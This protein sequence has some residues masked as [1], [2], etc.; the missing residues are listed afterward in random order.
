MTYLDH[1]NENFPIRKTKEEKQRFRDYVIENLKE[2]GIE[3][4]V[5]RTKDGKN[6][7]VIV[8]D[9]TTATAVFTAHYD[10]PARSLFPNIMIP[11]NKLLFYSYQFV[12]II[13][14]LIISF[15]LAHIVGNVLLNDESAYYFTFLISYY[16]I[17][18]GMMRG[19][20]NKVNYN[21]NTSGVATVMSIIEGLSAEELTRTAFILFDNEEK[22]K[23]GSAA[24]FKD[25]KDA[26]KDKF[27][28]NF[29]CVGNGNNVIFIAQKDAVGSEEF[30][31]LAESFGANDK[32]TLDFCTHKEA[33]SNSDHKNFPKGVACVACKKTNRGL[34]YTPYIHTP[35]D[36]VA[37]N[38]NIDYLSKN[39]IEFIRKT[40]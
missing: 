1:I 11:K 7:N 30:K 17:F 20:K 21:D 18:F 16:S 3:A 38:G 9:P 6:D 28:I 23:K 34:L 25:H 37:E 10:T 40:H 19:S 13:F 36:I 32:F 33:Q 8:G 14:L 15:T 31:T 39:T 29:D 4:R 35:K 24:Y 27:L 2:K 5:E 12:P 26:I 22:G